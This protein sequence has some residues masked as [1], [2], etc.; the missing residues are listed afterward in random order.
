MLKVE[1]KAL[2]ESLQQELDQRQ[3]A[4]NQGASDNNPWTNFKQ[5]ERDQLKQG[6]L[7]LKTTLQ[8]MF[9]AK[10]AYCESNDSGEIEHYWPK[11]AH[12]QNSNLGTAAKMFQWDNL[13]WACRT[14]NG[15]ECKGARMEWDASGKP[16]LLNPCRPNDDP[17]CYFDINL[18]N[19]STLTS[20][21]MTPKATLNATQ[22]DRAG[23][24]IRRLKLNQR[25]NL[26]QGRAKMAHDFLGWM[27]VLRAFG[28]DYE[29]PS[30]YTVRQRFF[31]LLKASEPYLAVVRQ[32]LYA[33]PTYSHLL[34]EL[35]THLPEIEPILT[36]WA[37][38][39]HDCLPTER[40]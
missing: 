22:T 29:A 4:L 19:N 33:D 1:R 3:T 6:Q 13:L 34:P 2:P 7:T 25:D 16:M 31:D 17:I 11:T 27:T 21:W 10:C 20:A 9:H 39:P 32:I 26:P 24:T 23:Y 28:P 18:T 38:P 15:F 8:A 35:L 14:C 36:E 30:G 12:P 40:E 37:L 5:H